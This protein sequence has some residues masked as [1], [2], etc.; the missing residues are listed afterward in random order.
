MKT[1][2]IVK[3]FMACVA[4]LLITFSS[5]PAGTVFA[6]SDDN[7]LSNVQPETKIKAD[8]TTDKEFYKAGDTAEL[9]L[10]VTGTDSEVNAENIVF[11]KDNSDVPE[12]INLEKNAETG[13]FSAS[14]PIENGVSTVVY[15][16]VYTAGEEETASAEITLNVD[17]YKPTINVADTAG[18]YKDKAVLTGNV[19]DEGGSGVNSLRINGEDLAFDAEGNFSKEITASGEY[20]FEATDKAGN[21]ADSVKI[22]VN[23][24][25]VKPKIDASADWSGNKVVVKINEAKDDGGSGIDGKIYYST[26]ELTD[27]NYSSANSIPYTENTTVELE[28]G[29]YYFYSRDMAGHLSEAAVIDMKDETAPTVT[30]EADTT[31]WTNKNIKITVKADDG[32][33]TGVKSVYYSTEKITVAEGTKLTEKDLTKN[34]YKTVTLNNNEGSITSTKNA[35]SS[36]GKTIYFFAV[37]YIGNISDEVSIV[38]KLDKTKPVISSAEVNDNGQ[39]RKGG[40]IADSVSIDVEASDELSGLDHIVYSGK[41]LAS[42]K[43][44]LSIDEKYHIKPDEDGKCSI[45][46]EQ[47]KAIIPDSTKHLESV[48]IYAVDNAGNVSDVKTAV[49]KVDHRAPRIA[50]VTAK[51][52]DIDEGLIESIRGIFGDRIA[53]IIESNYRYIANN[54]IQITITTVNDNSDVKI[55][56]YESEFGNSVAAESSDSGTYVFYSPVT[57]EDAEADTA[58]VTGTV[59]VKNQLGFSAE[60]AFTFKVDKTKPAVTLTATDD[61]KIA[62]STILYAEDVTKSLTYYVYGNSKEDAP[63]NGLALFENSSKI[64]LVASENGEYP[65]VDFDGHNYVWF[66]AIDDL[67]NISEIAE[68]KDTTAPQ[69]DKDKLKAIITDKDDNEMEDYLLLD[70]DKFVGEGESVKVSITINDLTAEGEMRSA[71]KLLRATDEN[72]K[73]YEEI[74]LTE[75]KEEN[76]YNVVDEFKEDQNTTYYYKTVDAAGN[77]SSVQKIN[78]RINNTS[79]EIDEYKNDHDNKWCTDNVI[80][81]VKATP[82]ATSGAAILKVV[83][84]PKEGT[85]NGN[86]QEAIDNKDGTYTFTFTDEQESTYEIYAVDNAGNESARTETVVKI[87]KTA[88]KMK[89]TAKINDAE[90]SDPAEPGWVKDGETLTIDFLINDVSNDKNNSSRSGL[91]MYYWEGQDK[92]DPEKIGSEEYKTLD[93]IKEGDYNYSASISF[94]DDQDNYYTFV[95]V[96]EAGN[97]LDKEGNS[98]EKTVHVQIDK[99]HPQ[100]TEITTNIPENSIDGWVNS[101]DGVNVTIKFNDESEKQIVSGMAKA[102]AVLKNKKQGTEEPQDLGLKVSDNEA[103]FTFKN[104]QEA[105]YEF[106]VQDAAGNIS[107]PVYTTIKIDREKPVIEIESSSEGKWTKDNVTVTVKVDDTDKVVK[108]KSGIKEVIAKPLSGSQNGKEQKAKLNE[109]GTYTFTF[110]DE[111]ESTYEIYAVDNAGNESDRKQTVVKTDKTVAEYIIT[112]TITAPG[113]K[114]VVAEKYAEPGWVKDGETLTIDFL[115]NDVSNDKNNS[116]RSGLTMYYW[117]GQDKF[118]PEKIGSE[119]YKTLD[120]IKEGDYNY[121]ASISFS[122]DQDNYYTFVVVDEAGN[123]LD[124]EGNSIEKTVHVQID[125]HHP[126]ITEITTNIPENSIDGWVNSEDGVNVTIKFNDESEKQIVSGMAK[127]YAVLKNKKQGT[128]EPKKLDLNYSDN[129]ATFTFKEPQE[130]EYE[131]YVVDAAGN[132]SNVESTTIKIDRE[133]PVIDIKSSSEDKWTNQNVTVDVTVSDPAGK[134]KTISGPVKIWT[135]MEKDGKIIVKSDDISSKD[136]KEDGTYRFT[137]TNEQNAKYTFYAVDAAGNISEGKSTIVKIDKTGADLTKAKFDFI[138]SYHFGNFYNKTIGIRVDHNNINNA[139]RDSDLSSPVVSV[140]MNNGNAPAVKQKVEKPNANGQWVFEIPKDAYKKDTLYEAITFT[141]KDEA[142]NEKTFTLK[143]LSQKDS[144]NVLDDEIKP[145]FGKTFTFPTPQYTNGDYRWYSYNNITATASFSDKDTNTADSSGI[146]AASI[147]TANKTTN[148]ELKQNATKSDVKHSMTLDVTSVEKDVKSNGEVSFTAE[149]SDIAGNKAVDR[150]ETVY[151]DTKAPEVTGFVA[152]G[153][154]IKGNF[155]SYAHCANNAVTVRLEA[156]DNTGTHTGASLVKYFNYTLHDVNGT[157]RYFSNV[158]ATQGSSNTAYADITIGT[159]FK[160]YITA[161]AVDNVGNE[162]E[163][164]MSDGIIVESQT[165]HNS[166]SKIKIDLPNSNASVNGAPLYNSDPSIKVTVDST[167]AG[168]AKVEYEVNYHNG[169]EPAKA[170]SYTSI[171]KDKNLDIS[172]NNTRTVGYNSNDIEFVVILTDMAGNVSKESAKFSIDKTAPIINVSYDNT[173]KNTAYNDKDYYNANRTATITITER[174]FDANALVAQIQSDTGVVPH[175]GA[176]TT[177]TN[178]ENPDATTHTAQVTFFEDAD[179]VFGLDFTDKAGSKSNHYGE[180]R[181]TIDK[182]IP[183]VDN[184]ELSGTPKNEKY[185]NAKQTVTVT[186]TEHNYDKELVNIT[187]VSGKLP[188]RDKWVFNELGNDQHSVSFELDD[189]GVYSFNVT[190]ADKAANNGDPKGKEQFVIDKTK[191]EVEIAAIENEKAYGYHVDV[192][193][194]IVGRDVNLDTVEYEI[195]KMTKNGGDPEDVKS[196]FKGTQDDK[197]EGGKKISTIKGIDISEKE[198]FDGIYTF[199]ATVTDK[200]GNSEKISKT[201]SV[202]R[203]GANFTITDKELRD[204]VINKYL[205]EGKDITINAI[206][207]TPISSEQI[208]VMLNDEART[209]SLGTDYTVRSEHEDGQWYFYSYTINKSVFDADGRYS[210]SIS[211]TDDAGN[212]S[213]SDNDAHQNEDNAGDIAFTIDKIKPVVTI[214][215]ADNEV[216]YKEQ[217]KEITIKFEDKNFDTSDFKNDIHVLVNQKEYTGDKLE[218]VNSETGSGVITVKINVTENDAEVVAYAFDPAGNESDHATLKFRLDQNW[219][220]RLISNNKGLFFGAIGGIAAIIGL[221]VFLIIKKKRR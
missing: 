92:F 91:T 112:S 197:E 26:T 218:V 44:V 183:R 9:T 68:A 57:F 70:A 84:E 7:P 49:V 5:V 99:H 145:E 81:I 135:E 40:W 178:T 69:F 192:K 139:K 141:V 136:I 194:E 42:A 93:L 107:D 175:I 193:P 185:Y 180:D 164:L 202:N 170:V 105:E 115:I 171:S 217:S 162:S 61:D 207:V 126:Q 15:K 101:E 168:V 157:E 96:D 13:S 1:K 128:E 86:V 53:F 176:F 12:A 31:E 116:S 199:T 216:S 163:V 90:Q 160:G 43:E 47:I 16:A 28:Q 56:G 58:S 109:D 71:V 59:K 148:Y 142:G 98:I 78:I 127:A 85:K 25:S 77:E 22:A 134:G 158:K 221:I 82:G 87:D 117:E 64:E 190:L 94:S 2:D 169:K 95:V 3:R 118:D 114:D 161:T 188:V 149:L 147:S 63:N 220:Q 74:D 60:Q 179:Y 209:L 196:I 191:P 146:K 103:T 36:S 124:K 153:K 181:F 33:G 174:N 166:S 133:K 152:D 48:Y 30:V 79:P 10:T 46:Y 130:A 200:A 32:I 24:D 150:T 189:D 104:P 137:F 120:L 88:A 111:Q 17:D 125:K 204:E 50:S 41:K 203:F 131:F 208:T 206:N 143:E 195:K 215:G 73:E 108:T 167:Y 106:Y 154:N 39:E 4:A 113:E 151:V 54:N 122:D 51:R 29:K 219:L 11:Y 89:M 80:V 186:I 66:A 198:E 27:K 144:G 155:G 83:A 67:G 119:E 75:N 129:E 213:S 6:E 21:P 173:R 110:T 102:Y 210:V 14:V 45:S 159:D 100:I 18:L 138:N 76:T 201:I 37:D 214:T 23:I 38:V 165:K 211:A 172:V 187:A 205:N 65:S 140:T 182:T 184:I 212:T 97:I 62:V 72:F 177:R 156:V 132:K 20:T 34:K 19:T 123:I 121:S 52:I 35:T 8:L 55:S